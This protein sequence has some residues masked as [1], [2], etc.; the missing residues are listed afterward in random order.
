MFVRYFLTVKVQFVGGIFMVGGLGVPEMLVILFIA[1]LIFGPKNLPKLGS[2]L[3]K[4]VRNIREG[5][6][7]S[8]EEEHPVKPTNPMPAD[9][10]STVSQQATAKTQTEQQGSD[11]STDE[12]KTA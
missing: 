9:A 8:D 12:K 7:E 6:E 1:V 11:S 10:T 2:A 4:T 3:G 5:M